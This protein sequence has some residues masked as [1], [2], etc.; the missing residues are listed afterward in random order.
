M[1]LDLLELIS[2][3]ETENNILHAEH[4]NPQF[5][6]AM[7]TIGFDKTYTRGEGAYLF[8]KDN[9][10][11][12][13]FLSGYG[14]YN[15]GRNHPIARD[16]LQQYLTY[17]AASLVQ[18]E[19]PLLS[20]ILAEELKKR[21]PKHLDT[22]YFT[23]S[24]AEC[25]ETA[26]KFA[27]CATTKPRI[28]YCDHAFHGLTNA[29]LSVNGDNFFRKGFE[30][31]DQHCYPVALNDIE[32]LEQELNKGDV[33]AVIVEPIQGKG[34]HIASDEFLHATAKLCQKHNSLFILDEVQTGFGRTG[35][36]FALECSN[37][38]PD[39]L[40][41]SKALSAGYVPIG[42]VMYR[43]AIY[44]KV[45]SSMERC[46]VHS[47]TFGQGGFAMAA[48]L[49]TLHIL[50]QEKLISNAEKMGALLLSGLQELANK[51]ESIAEIR[52]KGLMIGIEFKRPKSLK[53]K[54]C[55]DLANKIKKGLF[56]QA[57]VITLL[58][59]HNILTQVAGP[60]QEVIK[61]LPSLVITEDDVSHFLT[62]FAN[63]MERSQQFPG[64]IGEIINRVA[65]SLL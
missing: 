37:C 49:A 46:V 34:V 38:E 9:N 39:I 43:R 35:K 54:M 64:P 57:I 15:I 31:L 65:K 58:T 32:S 24:G 5:V 13:D 20:S 4:I 1:S 33:A 21:V 2:Q 55:W 25:V 27:R 45:F 50:E 52:G 51:Y 18:M 14:V 60:Q 40:L 29:A 53:Q 36:M 23:N 56:S 7:K 17:D 11:Y 41:I 48:G 6:K 22:V 16:V 10:K 47:S 42:A 44:K 12:I 61:L 28:L 8:D 3:R 30:P 59:Q 19:A 63:V 62:A 26:I